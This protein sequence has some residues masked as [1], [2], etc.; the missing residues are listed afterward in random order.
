MA[1]HRLLR[2]STN[3]GLSLPCTQCSANTPDAHFTWCCAMP[4]C[5]NC[6]D[7]HGFCDQGED[8]E[9]NPDDD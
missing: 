9:N 4:M 2:P 6:A 5:D 8:D 7:R 3:D 1:K